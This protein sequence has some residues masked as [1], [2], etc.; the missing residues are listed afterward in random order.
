MARLSEHLDYATVL[1]LSTVNHPI[2]QDVGFVSWIVS[3]LFCNDVSDCTIVLFPH[4]TTFINLAKSSKVGCGVLKVCDILILFQF[5][6]GGIASYFFPSFCFFFMFSFK[7][8]EFV[9]NSWGHVSYLDLIVECLLASEETPLENRERCWPKASPINGHACP[10]GLDSTI[11]LSTE[12]LLNA[13]KRRHQGDFL[14]LDVTKTRKEASCLFLAL[15]NVSSRMGKIW[16]N[17]SAAKF[18][19]RDYFFESTLAT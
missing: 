4:L 16:R 13:D 15:R 1:K 2:Y 12:M 11:R 10:S 8:S 19:S 9:V 3:A 6:P 5:S 17:F 14:P 7:E 18:H